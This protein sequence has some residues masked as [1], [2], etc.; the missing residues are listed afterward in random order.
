M[1]PC[2]EIGAFHDKARRVREFRRRFFLAFA[3]VVHY[4]DNGVFAE[5]GKDLLFDRFEK[6]FSDTVYYYRDITFEIAYLAFRKVR[7]GEICKGIH[8]PS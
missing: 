6:F 7:R 3:A 1:I 4:D 8:K 5:I 2:R